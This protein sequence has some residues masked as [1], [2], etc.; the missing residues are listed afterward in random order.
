[1]T[2]TETTPA[3]AP[4][5]TKKPKTTEK[6]KKTD[7]AAT[8]KPTAKSS[9]KPAIA[10]QNG[11]TITFKVRSGL[12]ASSVAREMKEA[13]IIQNAKKFDNYL[14]KNGYAKKVYAGTYQ[15]PKGAS[16]YDIARIITRQD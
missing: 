10:S 16:Y 7:S 3:P 14:I 5:Q 9:D 13:G 1:M 8:P 6:P 12:L 4:K 2:G 15:I 11:D